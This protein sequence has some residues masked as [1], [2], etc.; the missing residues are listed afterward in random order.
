MNRRELLA[1]GGSAFGASALVASLSGCLAGPLVGHPEVRQESGQTV[2]RTIHTPLTDESAAPAF[3]TLVVGERG[4]S[5][6][7]RKPVQ[8]WVRNDTDE[9]REVR[10]ELAENAD[11]DADPWF[12]R[13]YDFD[14]GAQFVVEL[15][16]PG[17]YAAT[18]RVGDRAQTV[19]VPKSW[20]DCNDSAM[21]AVV[22]EEKIE[23]TGIT[24]GEGC[25]SF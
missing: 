14:P 19:E 1:A 23:T 3:A 8:V 4:A 9:R 6:G 21:E 2:E 25:A 10:F 7:E 24:T 11:A 20:F 15:R 22:R 13:T 12:A 5:L 17:E 16:T 18:V